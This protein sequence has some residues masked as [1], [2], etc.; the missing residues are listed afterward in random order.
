MKKKQDDHVIAKDDD[1][2]DD[3]DKH[4]VP[5][6]YADLLLRIS[7]LQGNIYMQSKPSFV[8]V[9]D[10]SIS[11]IVCRSVC[12]SEPTNN[13]ILQSLKSLQRQ[14]FRFRL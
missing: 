10:C 6:R 9:Q 8:A 4:S 2:D 5:I 12:W 1:T 11:D 14:R 13:Q 3:K 7:E